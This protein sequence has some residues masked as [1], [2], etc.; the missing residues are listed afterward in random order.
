MSQVIL[1]V[2][3][4]KLHAG[5]LVEVRPWEEIESTLDEN[6]CLDSLPFMPEMKEYCGKRLRVYKRGHRVCVEHHK[7][8]GMEDTVFLD[9]V[10][11]TGSAH[12]DCRVGCMIFWKESWLRRVDERRETGGS[13]PAANARRVNLISQEPEGRYVCQ[14][15]ELSK[16]TF[17]LG[18]MG[19]GY[20]Y[21][22]DLRFG[23]LKICE[24]VK[25]IFLYAH[26]KLG[27]RSWT[28]ECGTLL[29]EL[30][31]T[32]VE[33]LSLQAGDWVEVKTAEEIRATLDSLGRNRGLLFVPE[34]LSYCG[35][36]FRVRTRLENAINEQNGQMLHLSNT[37]ILDGV[38]CNGVCRRGCPRNGFHYWREIWLR[39]TDPPTE[40]ERAA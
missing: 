5:E 15:S 24:F 37:V 8:R 14:S 9:E 32:P 21:V 4:P 11:C 26:S 36:Q 18:L 34:L 30:R 31:K 22:L 38:T 17:P 10:R 2:K 6:G 39:K 25:A 7:A 3:S 27:R 20:S 40:V 28:K 12:D 33:S 19:N 16:A 29:G 23:N 13:F 35:R 1:S